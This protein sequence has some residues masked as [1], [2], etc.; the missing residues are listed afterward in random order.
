MVYL[1]NQVCTTNK[2]NIN[3]TY[4]APSTSNQNSF[5]E[6]RNRVIVNMPKQYIAKDNTIATEKGKISNRGSEYLFLSPCQDTVRDCFRLMNIKTKRILK[7]RSITAIEEFKLLDNDDYNDMPVL[8]LDSDST[9]KKKGTLRNS[10]HVKLDDEQNL[11]YNM[12]K[13]VL[14][15]FNER[16]NRATVME[17]NITDPT[18]IKETIVECEDREEW[19]KSIKK[20]YF[21]LVEYQTWEDIEEGESTKK[22]ID[23]KFIFKVKRD[24]DN[25]S[26]KRKS[27]L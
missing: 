21:D 9:I 17:T 8:V 5:I 1:I 25:K 14:C 3:R 23:M 15:K 16:A 11:P 26:V 27:R 13:N 19:I 10:C 4:T 2:I 22:P 18:S 12:S 6:S 24:A 20:E 7:N